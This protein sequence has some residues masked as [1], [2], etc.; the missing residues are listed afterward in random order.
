MIQKDRVISCIGGEQFLQV[1]LNGQY[2]NPAKKRYPPNPNGY[3]ECDKCN[4]RGIDSCI[5]WNEYD[6]CMNC[7]VE[8][9][10]TINSYKNLENM[11]TI[12]PSPNDIETPDKPQYPHIPDDGDY[13]TLVTK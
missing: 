10:G 6:L 13:V 2:F 9:E 1:Y 7:I 8:I 3:V 4:K 5:S 11:P 12:I